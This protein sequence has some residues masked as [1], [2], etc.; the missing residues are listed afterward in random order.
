[1]IKMVTPE[2]CLACGVISI[3]SVLIT[4]I[5]GTRLLLKYYKF[6]DKNLLFVSLAYLLIWSAWWPSSI[7]FV[8]Y[9]FAGIGLPFVLYI[10]IGNFFLPIA[11]F[12]WVIPMFNFLSVK[13]KKKIIGY[14]LCLA[15]LV[16]FEAAVIYYVLNPDQLGYLRNPLV[17]MYAFSFYFLMM[18]LILVFVIL[19]LLFARE[20]FKSDK[21]EI[22]LKGRF[23][24]IAF[25]IIVVGVILEIFLP[26]D[27]FLLISR[28]IIVIGMVLLFIGFVMPKWIKALFVKSTAE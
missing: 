18:P 4:I 24:A 27:Y 23:L 3:I 5:L 15:Y 11:L 13:G 26:G 7:S 25:I 17:P 22:R 19:G 16:V 8:I 1:M 28:S 14:I 10:F 6:K 21:P 20:S 9:I 12:L 2:I